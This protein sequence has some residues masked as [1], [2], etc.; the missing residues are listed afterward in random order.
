MVFPDGGG[1]FVPL[2]AASP[3]SNRPMDAITDRKRSTGSISS[4]RSYE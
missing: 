4:Q 2:L 1:R 3:D